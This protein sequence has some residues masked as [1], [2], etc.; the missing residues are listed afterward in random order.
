MTA[1][2][3]R[4]GAEVEAPES[5]R[6]PWCP[7]CRSEQETLNDTWHEMKAMCQY[8]CLGKIHHGIEESAADHVLSLGGS[9]HYYECN[10]ECEWTDDHTGA[11]RNGPH[12]HVASS[13]IPRR[14]RSWV[15]ES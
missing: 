3:V 7:E 4:C 14:M 11:D 6:F 2:C 12:W 8:E 10:C 9:A 13:T 15:V 1:A 5:E